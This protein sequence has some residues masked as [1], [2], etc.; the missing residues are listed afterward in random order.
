MVNVCRLMLV[1]VAL[2]VA[3]QSARA[4][5]TEDIRLSVT[6]FAV[7]GDNP[8]SDAE[9]QALLAPYRGEHSGLAALETAANALELAMRARGYAFHRVILPPQTLGGEVVTLKVLRFTLGAVNVTGNQHFSQDNVLRSLPELKSGATPNTQRLARSLAIGNEH[10]SKR[11]ALTMR[12]AAGPDTID[13]E[14]R[15]QDVNPQQLFAALSNTGRRDTGWYRATFGYQHSNLFDRD[16]ALTVSYTTSPNHLSDVQQYGLNYWV[17]F[18]AVGGSLAAYYVYS[19][20]D[21]GRVADFFQVSGRGEFYGARYTH[22]FPRRDNYSHKLA[23]AFDSRYFKN[24]V[25]FAGTPIG[26]NI[27]SR[28]LSLRYSGN[29]DHVWGNAGFFAEYAHNVSGGSDNND[30]S[31]AASRAGA[32]QNWQAMR[33][34][35][36]LNYAI[37]K[38]WNAAGRLRGQLAN[39][40]LI[41]GEQFGLGGAY[42]VRGFLERET[43]GDSGYFVN[44]ELW[45]PP[46]ARDLRLLAFVDAGRRTFDV[47]VPGQPDALNIASVGAGVRWQWQRRLDVA[48]DAAY[49]LDGIPG[50]TAS[51]D[52]RIH[53]NL[54]YRF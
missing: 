40:A 41:A 21:S 52:K 6:R 13:A 20:V 8:L 39:E 5:E 25:S 42:S 29:A 30:V 22:A 50:A 31:Y 43:A 46:V 17:P 3:L 51:G 32:S 26:A 35:A 28:P 36:D 38:G 37:S 54:I 11:T 12:E 16:H 14:V 53:F 24:D 23:A 48:A 1:L 33:Y 2:C 7:E 34:G 47:A 44:L 49:V 18:Y 15:V 10:P 9:T 45:S 4:V 27:G 19:D